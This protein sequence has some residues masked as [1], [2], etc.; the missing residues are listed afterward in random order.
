MAV[1]FFF[2]FFFFL[3]YD[4]KTCVILDAFELPMISGNGIRHLAI[5]RIGDFKINLSLGLPK[6]KVS[7]RG[8]LANNVKIQIVHKKNQH[9]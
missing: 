9:N 4:P 8:S 6:R 5:Q 7:N 3:G 2:F 1:V